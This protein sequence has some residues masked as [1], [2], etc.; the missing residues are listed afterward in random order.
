MFSV[1]FIFAVFRCFI[2][3]GFLLG[4]RTQ[5]LTSCHV[6]RAVWSGSDTPISRD[7]PHVKFRTTYLCVFQYEVV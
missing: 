2:N 3:S 1:T 4:S 7:N 5:R 6:L